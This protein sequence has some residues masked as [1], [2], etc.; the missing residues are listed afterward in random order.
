[1]RPL[2]DDSAGFVCAESREMRSSAVGCVHLTPQ[3]T[4]ADELVYV[5]RYEVGF[6]LADF[7]NIA[8][9]GIFRV[10][11]QKHQNIE[12]GLREI[13]FVAQRSAYSTVGS[14]YS[15]MVISIPV[16]ISKCSFQW[17]K[18]ILHV[19]NIYIWKGLAYIYFM[20]EYFTYEW[21]IYMKH[22]NMTPSGL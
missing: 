1:M 5:D 4:F 20:Y 3:I 19:C 6:D 7:H 9:G 22:I 17:D 2:F 10:V 16:F 12:R 18:I 11:R 15:F 14:R 13:Q 8:C 21:F